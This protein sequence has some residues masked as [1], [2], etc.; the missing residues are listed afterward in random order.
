M[1]AQCV[2]R[3][4]NQ[5]SLCI[6]HTA[7]MYLWMYWSSRA[8]LLSVFLS[9]YVIDMYM[10]IMFIY[11]YIYHVLHTYIYTC[12]YIWVYMPIQVSFFLQYRIFFSSTR[13]VAMC[14]L[15][16]VPAPPRTCDPFPSCMSQWNLMCP[17]MWEEIVKWHFPERGS[18]FSGGH[19]VG[20]SYGTQQ[21]CIFLLK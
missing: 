16:F 7:C 1:H 2:F 19:H 14:P 21:L 8:S 3:M 20:V 6:L 12:I 13:P 9:L 11:I 5:I 18:M 4:F 15:R 17:M 10:F